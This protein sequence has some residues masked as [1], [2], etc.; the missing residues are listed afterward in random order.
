MRKRVSRVRG[1]R[2]WHPKKC[3]D[4]LSK[5]APIMRD[6][7][8]ELIRDLAEYHITT[9]GPF[10]NGLLTGCAT[11][12]AV[13][14]DKLYLEVSPEQPLA[15]SVRETILAAMGFLS[16]ELSRNAFQPRFNIDQDNESE[17]WIDGYLKAVE[18]HE[19]QWQEENEY[20]PVASTSLIM[21]HAMSDEHLR[22]DLNM[23]LPGPEDLKANPQ[24]ISDLVLSIYDEFHGDPDHDFGLLADDDLES[25]PTF[26][27][28]ELFGLVIACG[29]QLSLAVVQECA[30]REGAMVPLLRRHLKDAA[31][32]GD[33]VDEGDWW[34]LLH[35]VH[36]L[37]LIP[38]EASAE[39]L[40]G[41]F[42]RINFDENSNLSDWLSAYWPALCQ[43]KIE[44]T[45]TPLREIAQDPKR[46]WYARAQAVDCVLA[47]ATKKGPAELEQAIDW[48]AAMCGDDAEDLEFRVIAGNNLLD[49]PR[50]KHRPVMKKLVALQEPDSLVANAFGLEEIDHSFDEGDDPEWVRFDNPWQ[51]YDPDQIQRRQDRWLTEDGDPIE[52]LNTHVR[53]HAKIR[54]NEPCPCGSGKKYKKCCMNG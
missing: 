50:E 38:G 1:L 16:E 49:F 32:W 42:R 10:L 27:D 47:E 20:S 18:I 12:A 24:L 2:R 48:L 46:P 31:N 44:F 53:E 4:N 36:I 41:A 39:A 54:R 21:L 3:R 37:G 22:N 13:D 9:D 26:T 19:E 29:D 43:N 11:I 25:L 34:A 33:N 35:A 17:R 40:L 28:E 5:L 7:F 8:D 30:K 52:P 45:T 14:L 23:N 15:G 51:F 6:Y